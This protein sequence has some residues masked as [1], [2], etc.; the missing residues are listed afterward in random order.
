LKEISFEE[1]MKGF[2]SKEV[3]FLCGGGLLMAEVSPNE[4]RA[5]LVPLKFNMG[6]GIII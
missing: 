2:S 3:S 1:N 6:L 5:Q 4:E